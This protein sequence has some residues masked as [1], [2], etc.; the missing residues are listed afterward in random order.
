MLKIAPKEPLKMV[1]TNKRLFKE[2][3]IVKFQ[4]ATSMKIII[5]E[6]GSKTFCKL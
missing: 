2:V 6:L 3:S 5:A 1:T 4:Q